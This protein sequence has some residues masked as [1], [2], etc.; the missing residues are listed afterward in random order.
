MGKNKDK[1]W[2]DGA[3]NQ[4]SGDYD[5][6]KSV[7]DSAKKNGGVGWDGGSF[8]SYMAKGDANR[9]YTDKNGQSRTLTTGQSMTPMAANPQ[10][11]KQTDMLRQAGISGNEA[12]H[13]AHSAGITN[14]NSK[15]DIKSIIK[16]HDQANVSHAEMENY[17]KK[18]GGKGEADPGPTFTPRE[19]SAEHLAA[20]ENYDSQFADGNP[21]DMPD[22]TDAYN[23]T[24]NDVTNEGS[25]L[26]YVNN[27][28]DAKGDWLS[29]RFM[30]YISSKNELG[31]HEQ[32]HA[33]SNAIDKA[34]E[35]GI[36]PPELDDPYELYSKYKKDLEDID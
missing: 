30:P 12:Y 31:R 22:A 26:Q 4:V 25:A 27:L 6:G 1:Q 3:Y 13:L 36:K 19:K 21:M 32:H 7:S 17:M 24:F 15:N 33:M 14:V 11:R 20:Q 8:D 35:F 5:L 2:W 34:V 18:N 29:N 28:A 10:I 23:K 16:A 9:T